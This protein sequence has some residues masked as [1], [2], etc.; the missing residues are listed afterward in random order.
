MA[1]KFEKIEAGMRLSDVHSQRMGN[2]SMS[3]LDC[4]P[5]DVI[6]VDQTKRTA[7]V[8]WNGNTAQTWDARRLEKLYREDKLPKAYR[9][10]EARGR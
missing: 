3:R 4:W 7:L 9:D 8:R 10:Q 1:I 2:A 6:S 5:V